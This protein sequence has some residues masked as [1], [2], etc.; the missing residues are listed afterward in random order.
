MTSV[1]GFY[2]SS[3]LLTFSTGAL[4]RRQ[5]MTDAGQAVSRESNILVSFCLRRLN[6]LFAFCRWIDLFQGR[7]TSFSPK[8]SHHVVVSNSSSMATSCNPVLPSAPLGRDL[9]VRLHASVINHPARHGQHLVLTLARVHCPHLLCLLDTGIM[10]TAKKILKVETARWW[11]D[12]YKINKG[13]YCF[14]R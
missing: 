13:I 10:Q 5:K 1:P 14:L 11:H 4:Q 12:C 7:R 2:Q 6:F 8:R 3:R 9:L